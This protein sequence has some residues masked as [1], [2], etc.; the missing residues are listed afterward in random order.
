MRKRKTIYLILALIFVAMAGVAVYNIANKDIGDMQDK[1]AYED[2]AEL[3]FADEDVGKTND[4]KS[5]ELPTNTKTTPNFKQLK[6]TNE[7]CVGWIQMYGSVINYPVVWRSYDTE[8]FLKHIFNG[9]WGRAGTIYISEECD[10]HFGSQNTILF[11]LNM[12]NGTMFAPLESFKDQEFADAHKEIKYWS[13][14]GKKY[15]L[16]PFAGFYTTGSDDYL[17]VNF[18]SGE[19]FINYVND[20]LSRSTFRSN[21]QINENDKIVTLST[22]A[23]N[24]SDGRYVLYCKLYEYE[25]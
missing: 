16:V 14:D 7:H 20:K 3:A 10:P 22:C 13:D 19:A 9:A 18:E 2:I 8:F 12:F 23:Y 17:Y 5:G 4:S 25:N 6:E 15:L 11:G 21:V 24:V 1:D